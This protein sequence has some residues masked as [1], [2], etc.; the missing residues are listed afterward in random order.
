LPYEWIAFQAQFDDTEAARKRLYIFEIDPDAI[1]RLKDSRVGLDENHKE[2][3]QKRADDIESS[4]NLSLVDKDNGPILSRVGATNVRS[5]RFDERIK[6]AA[7]HFASHY[8]KMQKL[9]TPRVTTMNDDLRDAENSDGH[10][11]KIAAFD[12]MVGAPTPDLRHDVDAL[13]IEMQAF[14]T[15]TRVDAAELSY[16]S[17]QELLEKVQEGRWFV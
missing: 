17:D 2:A 10:Q 5:Q 14:G 11:R 1:Q 3:I 9:T 4:F 12:V 13:A 15:V 8:T 7:K 16:L 6:A